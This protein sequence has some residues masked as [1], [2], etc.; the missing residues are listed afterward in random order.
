[1]STTEHITDPVTLETAVREVTLE[2]NAIRP[3]PFSIDGVRSVVHT[4]YPEAWWGEDIVEV[5]CEH[6]YISH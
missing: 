4:L 6:L 2:L 3:H 1:M 5:V